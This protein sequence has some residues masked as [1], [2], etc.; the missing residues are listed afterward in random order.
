MNTVRM[1]EPFTTSEHPTAPRGKRVTLHVP[2]CTEVGPG[3][4]THWGAGAVVRFD[5]ECPGC[6]PLGGLL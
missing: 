6:E 1:P 4:R 2:T 3:I 5:V